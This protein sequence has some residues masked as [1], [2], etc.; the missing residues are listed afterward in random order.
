MQSAELTVELTVRCPSCHA[1]DYQVSRREVG[2]GDVLW[3]V[4]RCRRCSQ[5][6]RYGV[7]AIGR[8]V[9]T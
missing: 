9:R 2:T 3:H 8:P 6:F 1:A 7:D 5:A 4:C